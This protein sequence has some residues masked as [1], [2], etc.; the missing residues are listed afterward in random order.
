MPVHIKPSP[1]KPEDTGSRLK[2]FLLLHCQAKKT[3]DV[4]ILAAG[5]LAA[6]PHTR[7]GL[8]AYPGVVAGVGAIGVGAGGSA[9]KGDLGG[10][11]EPV[12]CVCRQVGWGDMVSTSLQ[13]RIYSK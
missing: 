4:A 6:G 5:G 13:H 2:C 7:A 3:E 8:A 9:R 11:S 10:T 12:Y 1:A